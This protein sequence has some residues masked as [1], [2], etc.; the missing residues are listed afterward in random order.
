MILAGQYLIAWLKLPI[1]TLAGSTATGNRCRGLSGG[2]PTAPEPVDR[3]N[4]R[5]ALALACGTCADDQPLPAVWHLP[6]AG[7]LGSSAQ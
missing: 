5:P 7:K 6:K 4:A 2:A 1:G 3:T